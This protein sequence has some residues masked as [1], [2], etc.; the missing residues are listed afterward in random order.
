MLAAM[1]RERGFR[2]PP[3]PVA[4]ETVREATKRVQLAK[5][6][7]A[8]VHKNEKKRADKAW[9]KKT[10]EAMDL[11]L[12]GDDD[13]DF[14]KNSDSDDQ[15]VMHFSDNEDGVQVIEDFE[16]Y[17]KHKKMKKELTQKKLER[18]AELRNVTKRE[19][20]LRNELDRLLK[21][22]LGAKRQS[23]LTSQKFPT[24]E[25]VFSSRRRRRCPPLSPPRWKSLDSRRRAV[26]L[27]RRRRVQSPAAPQARGG[28]EGFET[29]TR[30]RSRRKR[31]D[32]TR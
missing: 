29:L 11:G 24:R 18:E 31:N 28:C 8:I 20:S 23:A 19:I 27:D 25:G 15:D 7:D 26:Q 14:D 21:T 30:S 6:L 13:S 4:E 10:A 17:G 12:D 22:P 5:R 2:L 16:S 1:G 9:K 32:T 3:F